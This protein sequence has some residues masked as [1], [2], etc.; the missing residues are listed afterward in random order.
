MNDKFDGLITL[1]DA[2]VVFDKHESTL[3]TNIKNNKFKEGVDV[4]KFG[5]TWVFD[6]KSLEREYGVRS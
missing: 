4:K 3:K 5:T 2:C 1:K 6:I